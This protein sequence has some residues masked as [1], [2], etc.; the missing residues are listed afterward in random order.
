[1]SKHV[2]LGGN[3]IIGRETIGALLAEGRTVCSVARSMP[4]LP[5]ATPILADLRDAESAMVALRGADV[6]YLTVGVPY[7]TRAWR[8]DWPTIMQ[9]T[10]D[11]CLAHGTHLVFF[12]NVY[13]YGQVEGPMTES[14]PIRPCTRK[15]RVRASLLRIL[16]AASRE[17]GLS[18]NIGRSAD[19][20]GPGASTSVFNNFVIDNIAKGK[21]PVWLFDAHQPHSMTF[22]P[23]IGRALAVLGTDERARGRIWH[24]PTAPALTGADY[25]GLSGARP[26][27]RTMS[28]G[29]LRMGALFVP[30]A[31]ETL[32][33][34]YQYEAPYV[35]DSSAF[36]TTFGHTPTAYADGIAAARE[37]RQRTLQSTP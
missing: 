31:R 27:Y 32:E 8:R 37:H 17:R 20:Y 19:F 2:V 28:S 26:P 13:A 21:A 33:M 24:L 22:T 3:G 25:L 34:A 1:M 14:T 10:I 36:T 7:T 5:T 12:D 23:D 15:G 11:A 29:T 35:F 18:C 6:A 30:A 4:N 16:E 9:N